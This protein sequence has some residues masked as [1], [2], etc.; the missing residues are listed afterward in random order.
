M[1]PNATIDA[2][3][4]F[5]S[6][7]GMSSNLKTYFVALTADSLKVDGC[8]FGFTASEAGQCNTISDLAEKI[9]R[10]VSA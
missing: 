4:D 1:Y 7:L 6:D 10:K 9:F 2:D 8:G 5:N 3:T